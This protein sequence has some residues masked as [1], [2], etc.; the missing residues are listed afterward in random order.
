MR[1]GEKQINAAKSI[2]VDVFGKGE[3]YLFGSRTDEGKRGG[4]IDLY[5]KTEN[6]EN[7]TQKK[8]RFLAKLKREIGEQKIDVVFA[9]DSERAIEKEA[10]AN[11][12]LL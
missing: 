1:L 7:L 5:L 3:I 8:I 2:F 9:L 11:G 6:K 4:D 10:L 12:V